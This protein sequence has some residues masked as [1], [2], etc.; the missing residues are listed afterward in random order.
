MLNNTLAPTRQFTSTQY[1]FDLDIGFTLH[2]TANSLKSAQ[3]RVA[4]FL[5]RLTM[6][7]TRGTAERL[8]KAHDAAYIPLTFSLRNRGIQNVECWLTRFEAV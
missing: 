7:E 6:E 5:D 4:R 8:L 3:N 1:D 2:V